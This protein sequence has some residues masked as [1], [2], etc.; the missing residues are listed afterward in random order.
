M[1][2]SSPVVRDDGWSDFIGGTLWATRPV[3]G[4]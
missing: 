1:P 2:F 3:G 4:R